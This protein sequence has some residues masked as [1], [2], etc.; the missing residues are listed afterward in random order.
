MNIP[1]KKQH[2]DWI[3]EQVRAG[4]YASELEAIEDALAAR[5]EEDEIER[6]RARLEESIA[7]VDRGEVIAADDAYFE[8]KRRMIR[9]QYLKS[10]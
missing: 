4:R 5:I 8:E 1:L 7:Q 3:A 2:A 9:K 10:A 6:L